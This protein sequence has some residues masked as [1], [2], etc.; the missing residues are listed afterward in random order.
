MGGGKGEVEKYVFTVKPG[1]ILFEVG[2]AE[3]ELVYEG[4]AKAAAKLPFKT[5]VISR[6][7]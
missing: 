5:K 7:S 3:E 2:G 1:R 6:E 4:L